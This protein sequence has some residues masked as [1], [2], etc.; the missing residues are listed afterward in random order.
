MF[1]PLVL[2]KIS[3]FFL[4][5][6]PTYI[7]M[8]FGSLPAL[9]PDRLMQMALILVFILYFVFKTKKINRLKNYKSIVFIIFYYSL[10]N[11]C[12]SIFGSEN[13]AASISSLTNWFILGPFLLFFTFAFITKEK[14]INNLISTIILIMF[15]VNIIGLIEVCKGELLFK[16]FLITENEY[17]L[18]AMTENTRNGIYRIRSVFSNPLVY[19]QFLLAVIPLQFYNY[20]QKNSLIIK[21]LLFMDIGLSVFLLYKTGS[22]AGLALA[23]MMPC[24]KY[25]IAMYKKRWFKLVSIP[26]VIFFT[27]IIIIGVYNYTQENIATV[28]NLHTMNVHGQIDDETLST[29]ARVLQ[30]QLGF[31]SVKLHPISGIGFGEEMK[32]VEPLHS[33]DN[34]YLTLVL[35]TGIV[36][37]M[38][39]MT[40][41]FRVINRAIKNIKIYK[42]EM[43]VYLLVSFI[44][45]LV[46]YFILS[47][48]KANSLLFLIASLIYIKSQLLRKAHHE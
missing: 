18:G 1:K 4:I 24:L 40:V 2:F 38:F 36:G 26:I 37:L 29:L 3:L 20:K 39:F 8:K 9:S 47:I 16:N 17:T 34:Y 15:I 44:L 23:I 11:L 25:Y 19:A 30:F 7:A 28:N 31:E 46:Y 32:A 48:P 13:I 42:D 35:S 41:V 14:E 6:W 5:L 12:A 43:T 45:L 22:R 21:S 33:I 10:W 27:V